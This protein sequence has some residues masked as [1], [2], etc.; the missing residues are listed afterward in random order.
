MLNYFSAQVVSNYYAAEVGSASVI[1]SACYSHFCVE[2]S[3]YAQLYEF[4]VVKRFV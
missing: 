1:E 4:Q 3:V 2:S